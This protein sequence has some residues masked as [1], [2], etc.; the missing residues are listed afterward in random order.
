MKILRE[1]KEQLTIDK[2]ARL[3]QQER[4]LKMS[5]RKMC[6]DILKNETKIKYLNVLIKSFDYKNV[7]EQ[8]NKILPKD[9][10]RVET[11]PAEIFPVKDVDKIMK[12]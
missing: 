9:F 4:N 8:S 11:E 3:F 12:N 1:K 7:I 10:K 2:V 6:D 5:L